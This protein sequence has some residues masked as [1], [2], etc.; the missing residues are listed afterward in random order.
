MRIRYIEKSDNTKI[1]AVIR[2]VIIEMGA[3]KTGIAYEDQELD[4]MFEAYEKDRFIYFVVENGKQIFGGAG[5]APLKNGDP[6]ICELQKMYFLPEARGKGLGKQM[7]QRCIDF[8]KASN[9]EQCY[10]ETMPK[11]QDTQKLYIKAG[12]KYLDHSLGNTGHSS[13]SICMLKTL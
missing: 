9:F 8:T 1:A 2:K 4:A 5:I 13:C 3:P 6:L 10:I 12:F 11:M 7:I